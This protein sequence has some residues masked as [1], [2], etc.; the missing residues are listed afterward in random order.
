MIIAADNCGL[1][2]LNSNTE[3]QKHGGIQS[4]MI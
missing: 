4:E 1:V 3:A 2:R